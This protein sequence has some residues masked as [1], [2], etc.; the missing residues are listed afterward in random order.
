LT[1]VGLSTDLLYDYM[2]MTTHP[3]TLLDCVKSNAIAVSEF[4]D[5]MLDTGEVVH[6]M[7]NTRARTRASHQISYISVP[8]T[9][10][11]RGRLHVDKMACLHMQKFYTSFKLTLSGKQK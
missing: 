2:N 5:C 10:I 3:K 9:S 1:D 8:T 11:G 6:S 7:E 4:K